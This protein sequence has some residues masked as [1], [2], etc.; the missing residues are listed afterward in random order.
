MEYHHFFMGKLTISMAIFNSYVSLPEGKSPLDSPLNPHDDFPKIHGFYP[1]FLHQ[2]I[3][4]GRR[5]LTSLRSDCD[6]RTAIDGVWYGLCIYSYSILQD[7][8]PKLCLL[9]YNPI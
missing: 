8:P 3:Q 5:P 7:G 2:R 6:R 4:V 9:V 1:Y